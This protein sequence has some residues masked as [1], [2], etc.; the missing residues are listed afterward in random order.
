MM[1]CVRLLIVSLIRV[2]LQTLC[3]NYW[4]FCIPYIICYCYT[5][6]LLLYN[7]STLYL[8]Y[9]NEL[10]D[11]IRFLFRL[12]FLQNQRGAVWRNLFV[13]NLCD[14]VTSLN[15][16]VYSS[17]T[18]SPTLKLPWCFCAGSFKMLKNETG[19]ICW[20]WKWSIN[21][22]W[23]ANSSVSQKTPN[24]FKSS[25]GVEVLFDWNG[26]MYCVVYQDNL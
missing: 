17:T 3:W 15:Q 19:F 26:E 11:D 21:V 13:I 20:K 7:S 5:L 12:F 24:G 25:F 22:S 2:T 14:N 9:F 18:L 10:F 23:T 1:R 6:Y 16:D 8:G 4:V